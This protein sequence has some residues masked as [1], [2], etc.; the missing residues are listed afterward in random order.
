MASLWS[1]QEE[2]VDELRQKLLYTNLELEQL[3]T[4]KID[5]MRKNK[6]YVKQLIQILKIVCQERDEAKDEIQKLVNS[7]LIMK[8]TKANSSITESS[9]TYNYHNSSPKINSVSSPECSNNN[10]N[11]AYDRNVRFSDNCVT[12]L[13]LKVDKASLVIDNLVKGK[14]LPQQG[15]LLQA[16]IETGPILQTLLVF[17]Q[18]PQWRNPPQFTP[19]NIPQV[20]I[21]GDSY[22]SHPEDSRSL[23]ISQQMLSTCML[24]FASF[25]SGSCLENQSLNKFILGKRQRLY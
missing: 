22:L 2:T 12:Q 23:Q 24:N 7:P 13:A 14:T 10:V 18:L 21:K 25:D 3:K 9:V 17:G 5:E 20:S 8:S 16:V 6:E 15:K 11:A 19:F 1:Y 4:E